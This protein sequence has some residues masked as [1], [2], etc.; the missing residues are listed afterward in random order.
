MTVSYSPEVCREFEQAYQRLDLFRPAP[1]SRYDEGALLTYDME[2]VALRGAQ[3]KCRAE[4]RVERF[5]GGGFAGQ[6]YKVRVES[7]GPQGLPGVAVGGV[8]A[9]KILIPP[10][11]F[12][13][14]FRDALYAIG[15]QGS[16]Q[17]QCNP[18]AARSGALWQ[19]FIRRAARVRFGDERMVNDVHATFADTALGSMGELKRK[20]SD[21]FVLPGGVPGT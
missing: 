8:Y 5:V 14:W 20:T 15:F 2:P 18:A 9:L 12:S 4:V 6:V 13:K 11:A 19:K 17:P 21:R 10:S 3:K 7:L 16:F 1:A